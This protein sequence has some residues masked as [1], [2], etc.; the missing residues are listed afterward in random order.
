MAVEH[1]KTWRIG[2]VEVTRIV[3][4][5]DF[6]DH[7]NMTMVGAEPEE[8]IA[9]PWLHPH[10]ATPDG[11]QRMN[12]QGFVV[13]TPTRKLMV[14]TCIGAGR[15]RAFDVFTNLPE[16]FIEDLATLGIAPADIDI[17]MCTH[18]HHDHVGWN[19][20]LKDGV[21]VPTFPNARY[22]FG[23][24]EY[25]AWQN[26]LRHHHDPR[27]MVD[28][29]DPIVAAGLAE[30]VEADHRIC[31]EL[32][33]EP[34][35]GHTPGHVHVRISSKGEEAVI[36]GDLMH[37]PIQC[38]MPHRTA[39]FD[40]DADAGRATRVG[41]VEK[42]SDSGV[43]VIGAHFAH[44]TAGW[45]RTHDDGRQFVGAWA[46]E[47]SM[48]KPIPDYPL[49]IFTPACVREAREVDDA[50]REFAPVVRL[51]DGVMMLGRHEHVA[52]GLMDWKSWSSTS[53]P[54]HDPT[55]LRPEILLTDDPPRHTHVR[56]VIGD[57]LS[58]NAL[59]KMKTVFEA[60]AARL[61]AELR[62]SGGVVDAVGGI[63]QRFVYQVLPDVLGIPDEGREQMHGFSHMV[64]ATMGPP[65]ELFDEAMNEDFGPV[66]EWLGTACNREVLDPEGVGE[67]LYAAADRG[68]VTMDEA[69]LLLQTVL[70]AGADTTF[71]TMANAIRAW[72]L[73]PDEYASF[74][75]IPSCCAMPSTRACAG[76]RPR[77]W[78]GGSPR[79]TWRS[80][81]MSSPR[82]RAAD[83]CS[84]RATATRAS[85]TIRSPTGSIE[86]SST[87]SAGAMACMPASGAR[88]P[89]WRPPHC[90]AR[91]CAKW[92]RSRSPAITSPG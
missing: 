12:F 65:G 73:F 50:L 76:I 39:T 71:I 27:H 77:A 55:S 79:A 60:E 86:T 72:A 64:W 47:R 70:S 11:R 40:M 46:G 1:M 61:L 17:V 59:A 74:A 62:E 92:N 48:S 66:I 89:I 85:G 78:R 26:D 80:T 45:I 20:H 6:Q 2:D 38:A 18:L 87:G 88:S 14:D 25:E 84:Q 90:S 15:E 75:P 53:R 21:W 63:T 16:G 91:S 32:W 83:S 36:T 58:P 49:D 52:A 8:V 24:V 51:A 33:L 9:L 68:E 44:P 34:S 43:L 37:H 3:E 42:Y 69:K 28:S 19:T 57:A 5:W 31:D 22:L 82:A 4:M 67:Q 29:V 7:I 81:N 13:T 30:L 35:H 41:F 56:K 10:Y 23:R 54:W